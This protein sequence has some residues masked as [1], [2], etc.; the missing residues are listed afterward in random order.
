MSTTNPHPSRTTSDV[1]WHAH[2]IEW[3][4]EGK[5]HCRGLG[6][7][8]PRLER[9]REP[10]SIDS[11]LIRHAT[12]KKKGVTQH[13]EVPRVEVLD[14]HVRR[15][16]LELRMES[17]GRTREVHGRAVADDNDHDGSCDFGLQPHILLR[18]LHV[19]ARWLLR[20]PR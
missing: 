14:G 5:I 13:E 9:E 1:R 19:V 16:N 3:H 4:Q 6:L 12:P 17:G 2:K 10:R 18:A 11:A 7:P 20:T 15:P 8:D